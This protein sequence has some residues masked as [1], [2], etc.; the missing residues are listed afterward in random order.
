[1]RNGDEWRANKD[2]VFDC[3][4]NLYDPI[5]KRLRILPFPILSTEADGSKVA[6]LVIDGRGLLDID[7]KITVTFFQL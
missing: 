3:R 5:K 7:D 1:M 6:I 4:P 2:D